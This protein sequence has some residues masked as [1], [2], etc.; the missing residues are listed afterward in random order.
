MPKKYVIKKDEKGAKELVWRNTFLDKP[1]L[2]QAIRA[3]R[4]NFH[5]ISKEKLSLQSSIM[6]LTLKKKT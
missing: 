1:T 6:S 5:G 2:A 3:A 4:K